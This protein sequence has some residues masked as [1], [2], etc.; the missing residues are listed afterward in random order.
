LLLRFGSRPG[1]ADRLAEAV[2]VA[3]DADNIELARALTRLAAARI[4]DR[5]WDAVEPLLEELLGVCRR[6]ADDLPEVF[7]PLLVEALNL[8]V[9]VTAFEAPAGDRH[10][11]APP[12]DRVAGLDGVTAGRK[13]VELARA[14]ATADPQH[15]AL[16]GR[17]LFGL[18]RAVNRAGDVAEAAELLRE[19]VALR[20]ELYA[21]DPAGHRSD[22]AQAL[23]D[24]GNRLHVLGRSDEAERTAAEA[25]DRAST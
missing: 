7:R 18:D 14:L 16:L 24:L 13:A 20:R 9:L 10:P 25:D 8:V 11:G 12:R 4:V 21:E 5:R 17:A 19:C 6:W 3:R 22:L 15:R 1:G 2:E 23:G